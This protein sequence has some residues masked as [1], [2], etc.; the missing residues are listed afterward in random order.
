MLLLLQTTPLF[1]LVMKYMHTRMV[2]QPLAETPKFLQIR[3]DLLLILGTTDSVT[4][5]QYSYS[6]SYVLIL[7]PLKNVWSNKVLF[8]SRKKNKQKSYQHFNKTYVHDCTCSVRRLQAKVRWSFVVYFSNC[9]YPTVD[10]RAQRCQLS[11]LV[12]P[13][14]IWKPAPTS[15]LARDVGK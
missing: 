15:F 4:Y 1:F 5:V 2:Y 14:K 10:C 9:L 13:P 12:L 3:G 6:T 7:V 8:V 11:K